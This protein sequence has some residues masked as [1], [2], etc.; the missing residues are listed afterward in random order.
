MGNVG[1]PLPR[2]APCWFFLVFYGCVGRVWVCARL[3]LGGE[4]A[5]VWST[6]P[7]HY[8]YTYTTK[9]T[10]WLL[11]RS[12]TCPIFTFLWIFHGGAGAPK[13]LLCSAMGCVHPWICCHRGAGTVAGPRGA[14]PRRQSP[15]RSRVS[16]GVVCVGRG[17]RGKNGGTAC[18]LAAI[19]LW[20]LR[21]GTGCGCVS[22]SCLNQTKQTNTH[23]LTMYSMVR[24]P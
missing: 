24:T 6:S 13:Q 21:T 8:E 2:R 19:E 11:F 22:S 7:D 10:I 3:L 17:R 1:L 12:A 5:V 14:S 18:G 15:R 16:G 20:A 9:Y 23:V 4:A